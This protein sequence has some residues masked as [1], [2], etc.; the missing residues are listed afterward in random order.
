MTEKEI[1]SA[2]ISNLGAGGGTIGSVLQAFFYFLLKEDPVHLR[3]LREEIDTARAA[4]LLSSSVV[5]NA[6]AQRLLF[7]QACVCA[8]L[9]S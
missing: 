5:A 4:G 6:E 2:A 1:L 7:L 8:I 9:I 3:R